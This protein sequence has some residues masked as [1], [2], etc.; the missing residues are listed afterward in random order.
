MSVHSCKLHNEEPPP[1]GLYSI[2]CYSILY[3]YVIYY[4]IIH[5]IYYYIILVLEI[6][7]SYQTMWT[8]GWL[9]NVCC[10]DEKNMFTISLPVHYGNGLISSLPHCTSPHLP[11][12]KITVWGCH[13]HLL[14][15]ND[16]FKRIYA[17]VKRLHYHRKLNSKIQTKPCSLHLRNSYSLVGRRSQN[18]FLIEA[19]RR[20]GL[21]TFEKNGQK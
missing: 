1:K 14:R 15:I 12:P 21:H 16:T 17:V 18:H 2:D 4:Y 19:S 8:S 5:I 11:K 3:Y 10:Q 9:F 6:E 13:Q 7:L 20:Q